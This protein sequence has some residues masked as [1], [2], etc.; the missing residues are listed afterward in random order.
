MRA[1]YDMRGGVRGKYYERYYHGIVEQKTANST[2]TSWITAERC[3]CGDVFIHTACYL[4]PLPRGVQNSWR[5][6]IWV[7]G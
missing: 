7:N 2:K 3:V 6:G 4:S 1:E 5:R